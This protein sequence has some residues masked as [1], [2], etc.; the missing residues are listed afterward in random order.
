M[1]GR[2]ARPLSPARGRGRVVHGWPAGGRLTD[3]PGSS[4]YFEGGVVAYSNDVKVAL[5]GVADG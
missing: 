1:L 5:A 3:L 2:T 4:A